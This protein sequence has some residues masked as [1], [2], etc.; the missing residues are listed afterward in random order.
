MDKI[1]Y[2]WDF[3][4]NG[5]QIPEYNRAEKLILGIGL[6]KVDTKNLPSQAL[7]IIFNFIFVILRTKSYN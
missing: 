7:N 2:M 5:S 4:D 6:S 3:A 1:K